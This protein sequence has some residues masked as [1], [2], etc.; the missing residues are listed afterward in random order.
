MGGGGE[1]RGEH[2]N[3]DKTE[4]MPVVVIDEEG[5]ETHK[6]GY[7]TRYAKLF[8]AVTKK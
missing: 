4:A 7:I 3:Y 2:Y 5:G 1:G 8:K 6:N